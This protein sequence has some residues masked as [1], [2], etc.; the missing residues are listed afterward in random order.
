MSSL[1][2]YEDNE[3]L[4]G[5]DD[6]YESWESD[7]DEHSGMQYWVYDGKLV[8]GCSTGCTTGKS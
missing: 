8:R 6:S 1:D 3:S 5:S 7:E 4:D 2:S